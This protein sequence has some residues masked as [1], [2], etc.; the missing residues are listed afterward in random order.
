ME[1]ATRQEL[2]NL[3]EAGLESDDLQIARLAAEVSLLRRLDNLCKVN[4]NLEIDLT[5]INCAEFRLFVSEKSIS[6][7]QIFQNSKAPVTGIDVDEVRPIKSIQ[8]IQDRAFLF[9]HADGDARI[10]SAN[11]QQLADVAG[12]NTELWLTQGTK[13]VGSY[14]SNPDLYLD[15]VVSLMVRNL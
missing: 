10:P 9:I 13:H 2:T 4:E 8:L 7:T 6:Q 15:K 1:S 5:Y 14:Q 11:S 12:P 3:L